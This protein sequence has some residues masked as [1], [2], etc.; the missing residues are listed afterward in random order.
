MRP[1]TEG[2]PRTSSNV[3]E[4]AMS[5]QTQANALE[6]ADQERAEKRRIQDAGID[7][8]ASKWRYTVT[9]NR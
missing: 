6:Q 4:Y 2:A 9:A 5:R 7:S 1:K 8:N 3:S